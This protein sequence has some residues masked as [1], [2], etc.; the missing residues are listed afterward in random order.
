MELEFIR[1]IDEERLGRLRSLFDA[2]RD[3]D[4]HE[5]LGEHKWLDLIHG[6]RTFAGVIA[7]E[8]TDVIGYAHLSR[9]HEKDGAHWGLELVV[10]PEHRDGRVETEVLEAA[11][12]LATEDGGGHLHL[13][14][15]Q[16]SK[17]QN[18][19]ASRLGFRKGRDLLHM[20]VDLPLA[21]EPHF[22]PGVRLRSFEVGRDE[23]AWLEVNNRAFEHHPE[24][25]GWDRETLERRMAEDW[26]DPEGF[27]LA[28]D[29][30]G[31]AGFCWT[32]INPHCGEIYVVGVYPSHHGSGLGKSL[33]IAGLNY[34][35]SKG[36][37]TGCLYV[38][39]AQEAPLTMYQKLGFEVDHLDRA[40]AIDLA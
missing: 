38:D 26:F 22:P 24:Q 28:V 5:P 2:A 34:M 1:E 13:W 37:T 20:R 30:S 3:H 31:I 18:E 16:P 33:T 19:I 15:F 35:A 6:G 40:Y 9:H 12:R 7:R 29:D 36:A 39:A 8:G 27:L 17:V 4:H 32:K 21:V 14:A 11:L 10:H 23:V 25:G